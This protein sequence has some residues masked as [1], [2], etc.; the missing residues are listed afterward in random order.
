MRGSTASV[1]AHPTYPATLNGSAHH[2][3]ERTVGIART[4]DASVRAVVAKALIIG[5][6]ETPLLKPENTARQ[7]WNFSAMSRITS[8]ETKRSPRRSRTLLR[9]TQMS[10]LVSTSMTSIRAPYFCA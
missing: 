10:A 7:R 8:S 3:V 6:Y 9:V 1:S 4:M 2:T 5:V